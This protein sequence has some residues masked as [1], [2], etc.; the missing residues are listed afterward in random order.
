MKKV[1]GGFAL[2]T[3]GE[4]TERGRE[5]KGKEKGRENGEEGN[6]KGVVKEREGELGS[7]AIGDLEGVKKRRE[8]KDRGLEK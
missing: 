1:S 3:P 8:G 5:R 6:G 4:K 2:W 7:K